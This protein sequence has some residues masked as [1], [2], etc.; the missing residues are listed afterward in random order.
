METTKNKLPD[1]VN[2]FFYKLSK[3]LDTKLM[4]YGSVQRSDYFPGSSDIDV[5][6]FTDNVDSTIA[7]LQHFL[8]VKKK[9]FKKVVWRMSST[10]KMVYGYKIMY[11][12]PDINLAAEFSI[13]EDKYKKQ[14]LEMHLKKTIV[15]F[16]ITIIL[17]IIKKLYYDLHIINY[18]W[19]K[20]LKMKSLSFGLGMPEDQFLVLNVREEKDK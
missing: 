10:G 19:Y 1:K 18:D 17:Y 6:I 2:A 4:F 20:Y 9:K 14:V 15:P 11:E 3:Y 7:K 16:Y 5:D 13:Y 12:N 8:N